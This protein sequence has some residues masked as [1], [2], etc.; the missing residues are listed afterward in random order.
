MLRVYFVAGVSYSTLLHILWAK[1]LFMTD[2]MDLDTT[3]G[4]YTALDTFMA[5]FMDLFTTCGRYTVLD[6]FMA[7]FMDL[8]T[9]CGRYT[10]LDTF[11]SDFVCINVVKYNFSGV[12]GVQFSPSQIYPKWTTALGRLRLETL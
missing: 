6:T 8:D 1:I 2:F 4:R 10:V 11:M 12:M 3:C 9:T 5:D 7:D